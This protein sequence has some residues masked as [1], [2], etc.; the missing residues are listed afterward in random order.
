MLLPMNHEPMESIIIE[1]PVVDA[2]C[3]C[4]LGI[5][6]LIGLRA[7]GGIRIKADIPL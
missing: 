2:L 5:D 3:R 4:P 7:A 6:F 1:D